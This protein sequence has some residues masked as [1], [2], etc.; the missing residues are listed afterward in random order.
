MFISTEYLSSDK[1]VSVK[2]TYRLR[3]NRLDQ[4]EF[5]EY[6]PNQ[7]KIDPT[8]IRI[9]FRDSHFNITYNR[10]YINHEPIRI[11]HPDRLL[12]M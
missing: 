2:M 8:I 9:A 10:K 11:V 12:S 5:G 3:Q 4:T 7:I 1:Q 6:S